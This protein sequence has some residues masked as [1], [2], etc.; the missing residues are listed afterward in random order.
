MKQGPQLA[1]PCWA[2]KFEHSPAGRATSSPLYSMCPGKEGC[3]DKDKSPASRGWQKQVYNISPAG[4]MRNKGTVQSCLYASW[5]TIVQW[6]RISFSSS[7]GFPEMNQ[8]YR[9]HRT[10][11][12]LEEKL[13]ESGS[14]SLMFSTNLSHL[15]KLKNSDCSESLFFLF[16]PFS[17]QGS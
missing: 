14:P 2:H 17:K 8:R 7:L 6:Q 3:V 11:V 1:L 16:T 10:N 5:E 13:C 4:F 15:G 9:K 12:L